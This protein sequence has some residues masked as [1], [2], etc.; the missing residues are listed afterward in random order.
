MSDQLKPCP[1]CGSGETYVR[2]S[3]YWTGMRNMVLSATVM[4]H[5][6]EKPMQNFLQVKGKTVEDEIKKWNTRK[7]PETDK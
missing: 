5:C 7:L 4:H 3:D 1:F 6:E 2:T